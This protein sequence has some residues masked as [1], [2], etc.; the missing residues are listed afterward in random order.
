[1]VNKEDEMYKVDD[2]VFYR[3]ENGD[4]HCCGFNI[5][6]I[7]LKQSMNPNPKT[8]Y[9][10]MAIPAGVFYVVISGG[11]NKFSEK[12][13]EDAKEVEKDIYDRLLDL[14]AFSVIKKQTRKERGSSKKIT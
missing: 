13:E 6:S 11:N 7:L 2:L 9:E 14:S 3:D 5:N 8:N 12:N 1:M 4:V 10:N